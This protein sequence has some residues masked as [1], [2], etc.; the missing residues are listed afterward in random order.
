MIGFAAILSLLAMLASWVPGAA[1][2]S[3]V[4]LQP[5]SLQRTGELQMVI[6]TSSGD[7]AGATDARAQELQKRLNRKKR[8]NEMPLSQSWYKA[9][10]AHISK[11]QK[12]ALFSLW[13]QYGVDLKFNVSLDLPSLFPLAEPFTV[14]D[15]GFGAGES[16]HGLAKLF[17]DRQFIGCEIH[18]AGIASALLRVNDSSLSNVKLIRSDATVLLESHIGTSS[19]DEICVFFPDPWPNSDRDAERRIIRP[20]MLRQ[21]ERV[22]KPAGSVF[23]AT[24]VED[25]AAHVERTFAYSE[26]YRWELVGSLQH[27][28]GVRGNGDVD[29]AIC[30]EAES[31][32]VQP[33]EDRFSR[34]P[35]T[36]Y[37]RKAGEEGRG[38][39][40]F[41]YRLNA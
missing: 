36:K 10:Q 6:A 18:R 28:A 32:S 9:R 21:F 19:L 38:V 29:G 11:N 39:W 30:V 3:R 27:A 16:V 26:S 23:I 22:L 20:H 37:E 5:A 25:Y 35:V 1:A 8:R 7:L 33:I 4:A 15:I 13:P 40:E 17:P 34:R 2:L 31:G 14:L 12:R 24:D 41:E